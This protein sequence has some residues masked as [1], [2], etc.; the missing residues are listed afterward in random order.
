M[1]EDLY[2]QS[3]A[4]PVRLGVFYDGAF[5]GPLLHYYRHYYRLLRRL[6]LEDLHTE[7][8]R[9]AAGVFERPVEQVEIAEAHHVQGLGQPLAPAFASVLDR[10]KIQRHELPYNHG[11]NGGGSEGLTVEF[12]LTCFEAAIEV[13]LDMVVLI[14]GDPDYVPL[15]SWLIEDGIQV[16]VPRV[17]LMFPARNGLV[18]QVA[19]APRLLERASHTPCLDELLA[20]IRESGGERW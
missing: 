10:L 6:D 16:V 17:H 8:C 13:P 9:Y 11:R 1:S 7:M 3:F 12:A 19:T 4:G 14:T 18:Q 5:V 2:D 15:V 20:R